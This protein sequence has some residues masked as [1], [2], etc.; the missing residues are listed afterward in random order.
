[1]KISYNWLKQYINLSASPKE[2][3]EWLTQVGIEVSSITPYAPLSPSLVVGKIVEDA[4][5]P[6]ADRLRKV[7]VDIGQMKPLEIIC[8]SAL[9]TTGATVVVAPVGTVLCPIGERA[10]GVERR[11]S[12]CGSSDGGVCSATEGGWTGVE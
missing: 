7:K 4:G 5:H 1:M 3:A 10:S 11:S 12:S 6:K 2:V 9:A 8:G